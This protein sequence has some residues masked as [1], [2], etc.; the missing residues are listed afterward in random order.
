MTDSDVAEL[1]AVLK[2]TG[3]VGESDRQR[4]GLAL[5]SGFIRAGTDFTDVHQFGIINKPETFV[6][7]RAQLIEFAK[8]CESVGLGVGRVIAGMD[9]KPPVCRGESCRIDIHKGWHV[10]R[11]GDQWCAVGPNFTSLEESPVGF[12]PH[13]GGAVTNL[14]NELYKRDP[15]YSRNTKFMPDIGDFTVHQ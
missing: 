2:Q 7:T 15:E 3:A 14:R 12:G 8:S 1:G 6:C 11:D 10:Y 9:Q 4:V 13:I 5:V